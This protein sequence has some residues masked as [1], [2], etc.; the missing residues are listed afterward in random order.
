MISN[1]LSG[2]REYQLVFDAEGMAH[3][4]GILLKRKVKAANIVVKFP[5]QGRPP[6]DTL[7]DR[8][9]NANAVAQNVVDDVLEA[10]PLPLQKSPYD[11]KSPASAEYGPAVGMGK[12]LVGRES[13]AASPLRSPILG[14]SYQ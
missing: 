13:G 12:G 5:G 6:A 1:D 14:S 4:S 11:P 8:E 9:Q 2:N 7:N 10:Q 3:V